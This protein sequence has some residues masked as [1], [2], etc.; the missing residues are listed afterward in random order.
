MVRHESAELKTVIVEI[1]KSWIDAR[2][3]DMD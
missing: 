3:K 2:E 1:G